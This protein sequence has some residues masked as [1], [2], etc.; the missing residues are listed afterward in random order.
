MNTPQVNKPFPIPVNYFGMTLGLFS[1]GLA[2]RYAEQ[3]S[4]NVPT[5]MD[6]LILASSSIIWLGL[7]VTYLYKWLKARPAAQG[8]FNHPV[9]S[10]FISLIPIT[11]MLMGLT[12]LPYSYLLAACFIGIGTVAQLGFLAYRTGGL[13]QGTHN[14]LAQTPVLYLTNVATNFVS[15]IGL[16][17][18]G[19]IEIAYLFFG[20]GMF[21]WLSLEPAILRRLRNLGPLDP[22]LRPTLG[23]QLA[24]GFV[25]ASTLIHMLHGAPSHWVLILAGYGSL[26]LLIL[27]RL[28]PWILEKGFNMG[29]W[30]FSFGLGSMAYVGVYL[31]HALGTAPG[32]A[33]LGQAFFIIGNLGVFI[34]V[35]GTFYL[36]GRGKFLVK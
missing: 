30:A 22:A 10:G 36:I 21:S 16:A 27:L 13:L 23:I 24:P 29:F 12:L 14:D 1:L 26:Q 34:L 17:N 7:L 20:M 28:L 31:Q 11:T 15:T 4:L 35:A 9:L 6:H 3:A 33:T 19:Y 5:W 18:L 8:E 2:W 32:I 25:A